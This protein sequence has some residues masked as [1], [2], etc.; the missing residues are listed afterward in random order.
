MS[1]NVSTWQLKQFGCEMFES[2]DYENTSR[3]LQQYFGVRSMRCRHTPGKQVGEKIGP[4]VDIN[5]GFG[6]RSVLD[7]EIVIFVANDWLAGD[8]LFK[9]NA[10]QPS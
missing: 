8:R 4:L 9:Q 1:I 7:L 3:L 5:F 6:L 2:W 10:G